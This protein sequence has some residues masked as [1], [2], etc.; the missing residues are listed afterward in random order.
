M[1][2][3]LVAICLAA[4]FSFGFAAAEDPNAILDGQ[5]MYREGILPSGKPLAVK[6]DGGVAVPGMTFACGS[7]H[8]RSGLA[9]MDSV[10][11]TPSVNGPALLQPY[12]HFFNGL[13]PEEREDLP[14]RF[15]TPPLRPAY[16]DE[17]L[18]KAIR[19]G[20]DPN[21]RQFNS[22]MPRYELNDRDM[23]A[24]I[25]YLKQLSS[26]L[27][28]GVTDTTVGF[29]TVV[30]D[31]VS[32]ADQRAMLEPLD[33]MVQ[34][35]NTLG[36]APG[37]MSR[38]IPMRV[39]ALSFRNYTLDHWSLKGPA[40]TWRAQLESLYKANPV[41]ALVGGIS[42]QSWKPIHDFCEEHQMPCI[43]PITDL[44]EVSS[45]S[46]YTVYFSKGYQQEGEAVARH[47]AGKAGNIVQIL[48]PGAQA[49]ALAA[50]FDG[51]WKRAGE[52][53]IRTVRLAEGERL[54][55]ERLRQLAGK[56]TALLWMGAETLD[57]LDAL[58]KSSTRPAA[59]FMSSTLLAEHLWEVPA[60]ARAFTYFAY[61]WRQPG[62]KTLPA[63]MGRARPTIVDKDYRKNDRRIASKTA[64]IVALL[65][66]AVVRMDRNFYRDYV[67]DQFDAMEVL[68]NT[69]YE[70]LVPGPGRRY[71]SEECSIMRLA[72]GEDGKLISVSD[73]VQP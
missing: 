28:P 7:C 45:T 1:K 21:G 27:A 4:V 67:L 47:L 16:T 66:D 49:K 2:L 13:T 29:A 46:Y 6:M 63:K 73:S 37:T 24:L 65:T 5:R 61:P 35:H 59:V 55:G 52:K 25:R 64:T 41:F 14:E 8:N 34:V 57:A 54:T 50:G 62:P 53:P 11:R 60:G 38:M 58:A 19:D 12:Y 17:T 3:K 23:A 30:T 51:E 69:D 26:T 72:E 15:K 56:G 9:V 20:V 32:E 71:L 70:Q 39:M 22:T 10:Q 44:P 36:G 33:K 18:A 68:D 31:D 43:L 42:G 40:A 48:G